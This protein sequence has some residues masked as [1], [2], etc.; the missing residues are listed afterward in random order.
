MPSQTNRNEFQ[1][2]R[3]LAVT[4]GSVIK[5]D[6][7][8]ELLQYAPSTAKV[9]LRPILIVPPPIGRYY[10]LDLQ[11]GRSFVEHAVGRAGE[12]LWPSKHT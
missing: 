11:P 9:K 7:L 4:P 10:F 2:S 1:V 12:D 8:A 3:D 6:E 5:R